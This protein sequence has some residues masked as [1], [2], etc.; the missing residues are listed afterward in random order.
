[1]TETV[2]NRVI[3]ADAFPR[4]A[5]GWFSTLW[6]WL[7]RL[8]VITSILGVIAWI[9]LHPRAASHDGG[10]GGH[11]GHGGGHGGWSAMRGG[12]ATPVVA[13]DV[14]K[15]DINIEVEALGTVTS[16]TT[17][18]VKTQIGGQLT[19]IAFTEG[20]MVNTG[21][22]LAQVDPRPYQMALAQYEGQL[23][24]DQALLAAAKVDLTRYK[25]L[26]AED[27]IASQQLDTQVALVKQ[28]DG[29]VVT[30]TALVNTAKLNITYCHIV[31][32]LTGR[33][34]LRQVDQ[35]N[36]VQTSDANGIVTITQMR[37]I[38]VIAA[39]PEDALPSILKRLHAGATLT[40]TAYDRADV[41]KL[42]TGVL[43]ALDNQID[44]TTGT[45]KLRA[46]F[47]NQDESM[48]P[49]QFVNLR[50]LVSVLRNTLIIPTAAVQ[51]G[52]P[53][54][55]VYLVQT[56]NCPAP[57]PKETLGQDQSTSA[58]KAAKLCV[59]VRRVKLGSVSGDQVAVLSGLSLGDKV[60]TDGTDKLRE[61]AKITLPT[62]T[63]GSSGWGEHHANDS[64]ASAGAQGEWHHH[65]HADDSGSSADEQSG[66]HHHHHADDSGANAGNQIDG[67]QH[68][69][70][71]P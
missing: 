55:F 26:V 39:V 56:D 11:G 16:L 33:V 31:S 63:Q 70:A 57:D 13:A 51:T 1:M 22:F 12:A 66:W 9:V 46:R 65:H 29:T 47:D 36:Y 6:R 28:Y 42:A 7:L 34:G 68:N 15:G 4:R 20:Q 62:D 35:G 17:V 58:A 52:V 27:S 43:V 67:Y 24:H 23:N 50:I 41:N 44:P 30:D 48:Y 38:S 32:P 5:R 69:Q 18:T 3:A 19:K 61:G 2:D 59:T 37:P 49:N 45:I 71:A 64:G 21:E 40:A 54:T 10:H 53:G 8:V 25:N 60:V 14:T